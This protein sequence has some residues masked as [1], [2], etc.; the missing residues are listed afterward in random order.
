[1]LF[2]GAPR[3]IKLARG[4]NPKR[5]YADKDQLPSTW[6]RNFAVQRAALVEAQDYTREWD[7]YNAKVK[8]DDGDTKPPKHDLKLEALADVLRRKWLV[9][10]HCY[11]ADELLTVMAIAKEF[12]YTVRVSITRSKLTGWR[13]NSPL[14]AWLSPPS[15]TGGATNRRPGMRSPGRR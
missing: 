3:S 9:Q 8:R 7:D 14:R 5:A 13:T 1:M 12:G 6:M 4:E 11:R 15:P 10:I 2:P